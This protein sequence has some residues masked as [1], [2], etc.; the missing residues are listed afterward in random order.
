MS[1]QDFDKRT[2]AD[3]GELGGLR[4]EEGNTH[5]LPP[6]QV[7]KRKN[8]FFTWNNYT[9]EH[10]EH[11]LESFRRLGAIKWKFQEEI[12]PTT[13]TPHLQGMVMFPREKRSTE[14]DKA[15]LGHWEAL[16]QTDG[17]YQCKEETRKPNGRQWSYGFPKQVKIIEQLYPCQ[18][19]IEE[20]YLTEPNDRNVYWFWESNGN[21]G[22]SAFVKYMVVKYG[23]L[24]CDGGR[25]A[26]LVNLVFNANMDDT[27]CIIWDIPRA[28]RN[29]ISYSTIEAIK[30]GLICNTKYETGVKAFNPV[31]I[32]IFANFPPDM[33][34][35]TLSEDRWI[36][37]EL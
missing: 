17:S 22:K 14:W 3:L 27:R 35:D 33:N 9:E 16:K 21:V 15:S 4:R 30:N 10:I 36:I 34:E 31:H 19:K 25:K 29:K 1:P 7:P 37:T 12:A 18:K 13:G 8:H 6:K 11:L 23:C 32:F 5:Q 28:N 20:I 26:D 2:E 24:F